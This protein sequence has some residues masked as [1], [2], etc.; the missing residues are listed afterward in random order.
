MTLNSLFNIQHPILLAPM[1]GATTAELVVAVSEAGGLGGLGAAALTPE[2]LRR[3]I[4]AIRQQTEKPFNVNLFSP[5]VQ[6]FDPAARPG[7]AALALIEQYSRELGITTTPVLESQYPDPGEQLAIL[8]E[9]R[10]PIISFHFG[11]EPEHVEAIHDAG[12]MVLCS[13][14]TVAE[15]RHLDAIG[16]DAIIAQGSEAGGHRGTFIGDF[17]QALIGTLAL[18][19]Q[20]VDAVS[21]PVVAAGGIMD[22]RGIVAC[23]A[24]GAA[25]VQMGT[26]F[27]GCPESGIPRVWQEQLLRS[28]ADST[29]VT[30]AMSGRPARGLRNRYIE[31]MESLEEPLLPYPLQYALSASIRRAAIEQ[32]NPAFPAMW[33]GQ[34]VELLQIQ[35]AKALMDQFIRESRDL[36]GQLARDR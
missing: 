30:T 12:L 14:T 9:E 16:V 29:G 15:A 7:P 18:V 6:D 25:G 2:R 26:A 5:V 19:P 28:S 24:L 23:R 33:A 4:Q 22:A 32:H 31:E 3:Q 17:R 10:V 21:V 1:A 36:A 20:V 13:A 34:G 8:I 35:S 27:L 11:V